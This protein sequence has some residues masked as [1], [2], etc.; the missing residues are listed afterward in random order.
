MIPLIATSISSHPRRGFSLAV[1]AMALIGVD[2]A[3]AAES[4]C[5][6]A[7]DVKI[8]L[9]SESA[10]G[11]YELL[12]VDPVVA[13]GGRRSVRIKAVVLRDSRLGEELLMTCS[14]ADAT[15]CLVEYRRA[16]RRDGRCDRGGRSVIDL[17][18]SVSAQ[19]DRIVFQRRWD[20]ADR[21]VRMDCLDDE[22]QVGAPVACR[23]TLGSRI[24]ENT[25]R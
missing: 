14:H 12:S 16:G 24:K 4:R 11:L 23:L 7:R 5:Q 9:A 2:V 20:A 13:S 17:G 15:V 19:L 8:E 22:S 18:P 6:E 25:P 10:V 1:V 3:G 21:S